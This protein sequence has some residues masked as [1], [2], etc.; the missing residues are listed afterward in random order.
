M[1]GFVVDLQVTRADRGGDPFRLDVA[2]DSPPGVTIVFGPSGAGKS[3]LLLAILGALQPLGGRIEVGGRLLFDARDGLDLPLRRRRVGM[4]FQDPLLFPNLDVLRNVTFGLK[5]PDQAARAGALLGQVGAA[6]LARRRPEGLSGGERQRVALARA[7]AAQPRALL[8]DEPFSAL[9]AGAREELGRL[10]LDLQ[11]RHEIP[12]LHVTHDPAE[13]LR[14][15]DHLVMLDQGRVVRDGSPTDVITRPGSL[16]AAR[17]VGTE[18]LFT[19]T[20]LAHAETDGLSRVE[21]GGAEVCVGLLGEPAGSSVALGLR[22]EDVL[23]SLE[24]LHQTSARNVLPGTVLELRDRGPAVELLV[25][26]PA[27]M[28][29]LVTPVSVRELKLAPDRRVWLLIKASAFHRLT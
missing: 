6:S 7:L 29:V 21:I 16:A 27:P 9:D 23:L 20:V 10:L 3:T 1:S 26:T 5:G 25:A 12:F 14:L 11:R 22:A 15:G 13:A 28:R 17:A 2:F 24:P 4:V 19:G 18:N 8:L